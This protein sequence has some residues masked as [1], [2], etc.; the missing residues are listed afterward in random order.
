VAIFG[1]AEIGGRPQDAALDL[2][3]VRLD[4]PPGRAT[5][6]LALER[7]DGALTLAASVEEPAG[8]IIARLLD[9]PDLPPVSLQLDGTGPAAGWRGRLDARA[10]A[11]EAGLDLRLALGDRVD[12]AMA[13][14]VDPGGLAGEELRDLL[15]G[16]IGVDAAIGWVPGELIE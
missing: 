11:A 16:P 5:L 7:P 3:L 13:G 12:L 9:L 1:S 8:G 10:G 6:Q 15:P 2:D 14:E 4:G